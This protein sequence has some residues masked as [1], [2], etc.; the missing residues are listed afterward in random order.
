MKGARGGMTLVE[1][2]VA[3]AVAL[4]LTGSLLLLTAQAQRGF[5]TQPAAIDV[6]ERLR[7]GVEALQHDLLAAGSG[8]GV[9]LGGV[10][11]GALVPTIVPYRVG[12]RGADPPGVFRD[13]A[14]SVISAVAG[15]SVAILDAPFH[16]TAGTVALRPTP[17]CPIGQAS[18]G[19]E[20]GSAV[21]LVAATGQADL[22]G[23]SG[24]AT[25]AVTLEARGR[26]SGRLYPAGSWLVPVDVATY[27]LRAGTANEG[28]LLAR[29]DGYQSDL[30]AVDHIVRLAF[31]YYGDPRPPVVRS[32]AGVLADSTT[33]G[34]PPPAP[35]DDDA[36]DEWGAG[37]N[38]VIGMDG[39]RQVARLATLGADPTLRRLDAS[40][41]TDGPWCPDASAPSRYDADLLRIRRVRV[42]LRAEAAADTLRASDTR[43]FARPGRAAAGPR[44]VPD[45]QVVFDVVPRVGGGVGR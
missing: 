19:L 9:P 28:P 8:P 7:V 17:G 41:L 31:E 44:T 23:V 27:Y 5:A 12:L 38:C 30:P 39:G 24:V 14:V 26:A 16:G 32:A 4:L 45:Q 3:S 40:S 37:E 21:L 10:A 25:A 36:Q 1:L 35:G 43:L 15:G 42:T 20:P 34:P 29:Y 6:Q 11:L 13:D 22:L 33:Y 18:C 2:L